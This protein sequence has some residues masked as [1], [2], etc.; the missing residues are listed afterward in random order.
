MNSQE[1][2]QAF[3]SYFKDRGH[4]HLPSSGLI[5][6]NDPT[7]LF[8]N[9]GMNQFKDYFTGKSTPKNRRAVTVQKCV[10][11]GGKHNDLENVGH[12]ARHHTFFEMLGNF[13]F[14]DYFKLE[15]IQFA[16]EF[17]TQELR[18]DPKKLYVTVHHSDDEAYTIWR[19]QLNIP[20]ERIFRKG[21]KDNFWE[22]G[23]YGPCGPCSEIF[24][25]HGPEYSTPGLKLSDDQDILEDES[26]YIEIWNLV[27][28][29]YEKTPEGTRN[30]PNPC[31]DTGAGLER[32][33]A[34]IQGHYW[35]YDSDLFG[36]IIA[37]LEELTRHSYNDDKMT[38]RFRIIADHIKSSCM[39]I[40]DGV[41]PSNEG[42]GYVLRRII[43][44]AV[45][46]LREM[47]SPKTRLFQLVPSVFQILGDTYRENASNQTLA[48]KF[49]QLE[50]T[51]FLETLD[52]GLKYLNS[53]L[54]QSVNDNIFSGEAAFKLYDTYGFPLDLTEQILSERHLKVDTDKFKALMQ[55]RK[56][57]S[58]KSWKGGIPVD[59]KVFHEA[60]NTFGETKFEGHA[61]LTTS[62]KLLK[63][64]KIDTRFALLFDKTTFYG[65]SGGQ[66]GD[67]GTISFQGSIVSRIDD[68]QKPV[69][70]LHVHFTT[71]GDHLE[72]GQEYELAVDV[73]ERALTARNH[74]AT[75]LLQSALISILGDHVK[76]AGSSVDAKRLRFDFTHLQS[77]TREEIHQ[78]ETL[79]NQQIAAALGVE[80]SYMTK[81]QATDKGALAL[82][83]EKYGKQVR[84]LEMGTFSVE[85]CGG[86][87]VSNT[88]EIGLFSIVSEG[89]LSSGIRRIEAVTSETALQRLTERSDYLRD[90]EQLINAP[91]DQLSDRIS[92]LVADLKGLNKE[93]K[94][95]KDQSEARQTQ[96]L[97]DSSEKINGVD[98][99]VAEAP[100][101]SDMRKLSD[102][103][104]NKY[105]KGLLI[106]TQDKGENSGVLLRSTKKLS[107]DCGKS[108]KAAA[109][110]MNGRGG[111]RKD[112]A[113]GSGE[114]SLVKHF[115]E[116][117]REQLNSM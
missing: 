34:L 13:S 59:D 3:I 75:H 12:T 7:L 31:I 103:F 47:E 19:D 82:F 30:L 93:V 92:S 116:K 61:K 80:A 9:A 18:I 112:M 10:R 42:R 76:Q 29:Q 87:H 24:Y 58:R 70:N 38:S 16:W 23:E 33:A 73:K 22:M 99:V 91:A 106:L 57:D 52:Q 39:L 17:L 4:E 49:L 8:A 84:V 96:S 21:D 86:T 53:G 36:P 68:V 60:K 37:K 98:L 104:I 107:F 85:L 94:K 63:I 50:E 32:L 51:K 81:D 5:P 62:A 89:S 28:M 27:F 69:D 78:V 2:R 111:G 79:V 35:N 46:A 41:I 90:I 6:Y 101:E 54:D 48:E 1:I 44:R 56:E 64:I 102:G 83:G 97:F 74:S 100:K 108:F 65:E 66:A 14:G 20:E 55:K 77:L 109:D 110:V 67:K 117:V 113:Q 95:F 105:E 88:S 72:E 114:K 40:S 45:R 11:A 25:D 15:A 115:I 43:R 71:E 26:R